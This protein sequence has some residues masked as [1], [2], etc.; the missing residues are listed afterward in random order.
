[1]NKKS[2][3]VKKTRSSETQCA[4]DTLANFFAVLPATMIGD[5]ESGESKTCRSD[6]GGGA[7]V[8]SAGLAAVFY[9]AS[10]GICFFPKE[11]EAGA[12]EFFQKGVF[13]W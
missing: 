7:S 13:R 3:V 10:V 9:E 2:I 11:M 1:M 8:C 4:D 6:A 5:A 12:L